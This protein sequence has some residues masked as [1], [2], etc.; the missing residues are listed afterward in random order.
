MSHFISFVLLLLIG[1]GGFLIIYLAIDFFEYLKKYQSGVWEE[2][3]FEQPF[4]IPRE[5]FFFYPIKPLKFLSFLLS[6]D[7]SKDSDIFVY[8]KRITSS[9]I[10]LIAVILCNFIFRS[11]F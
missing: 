7:D 9:F 1:A 4:G 3:C 10:G 5:D 11:I 6:T 8:K 2:L